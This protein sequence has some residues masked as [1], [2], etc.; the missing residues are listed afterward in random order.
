VV[1][2]QWKA[3]SHKSNSVVEQSL[4]V[5]PVKVKFNPFGEFDSV[6]DGTLP[7]SITTS[8]LVTKHTRE[9]VTA[10]LFCELAHGLNPHRFPVMVIWFD[11]FPLVS[12]ADRFQLLKELKEYVT[13]RFAFLAISSEEQL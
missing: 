6:I 8:S 3:G 10:G 11:S 5:E 9:L 1:L 4:G 13:L 2:G 7:K 12:I